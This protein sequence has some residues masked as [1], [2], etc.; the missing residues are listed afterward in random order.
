[1]TVML[2]N[3]TNNPSPGNEAVRELCVLPT[4]FGA[5]FH[6]PTQELLNDLGDCIFLQGY[7]ASS[8]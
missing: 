1:M 8:L 4:S 7:K 2:K 3:N 6:K 5:L